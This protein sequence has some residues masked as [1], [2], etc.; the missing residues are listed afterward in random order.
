MT[1]WEVPCEICGHPFEEH[2]FDGGHAEGED[3]YPCNLLGCQCLG[4]SSPVGV[5]VVASWFF[6]G[7]PFLIRTVNEGNADRPQ[8]R[9]YL[10]LAKPRP[11]QAEVAAE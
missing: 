4:Y 7:E 10:L 5:V 9:W 6:H 11:R 2:D 1:I 3:P 8:V